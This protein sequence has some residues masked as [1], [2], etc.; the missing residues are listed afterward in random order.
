MQCPIC[1]P[2]GFHNPNVSCYKWLCWS[3]LSVKRLYRKQ[4]TFRDWPI[5]PNQV[6]GSTCVLGH[7]QCSVG[8]L[9]LLSTGD[10]QGHR[11]S[12]V[13]LPSISQWSCGS[14]PVVTSFEQNISVNLG[15]WSMSQILSNITQPKGTYTVILRLL[16]G[17]QGWPWNLGPAKSA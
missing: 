6:H 10:H 8:A 13:S 1:A 7:L 16:W 9:A 5:E 4:P 15:R 14:T 12:T 2:S 17:T 11:C 3:K